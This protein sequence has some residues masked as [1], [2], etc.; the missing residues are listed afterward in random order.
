[1]GT[2]LEKALLEN[3][4]KYTK[5]MTAKHLLLLKMSW[6]RKGKRNAMKRSIETQDE[7]KVVAAVVWIH[8]IIV[9]INKLL[10]TLVLW[11]FYKNGS[12]RTISNRFLA[13]S[14]VADVLVG[15]V[16]NP[17]WIVIRCWINNWWPSEAI[18]FKL[19]SPNSLS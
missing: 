15:L 16:I 12:L 18:I 4:I 17:F 11:L 9:I 7:L 13:S 2:L 8:S 1:M 3:E 6:Y 5:I 14:S 10:W 19:I